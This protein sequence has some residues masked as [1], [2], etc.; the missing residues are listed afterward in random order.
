VSEAEQT[1]RDFLS[2]SQFARA[3]AVITDLDGTALHQSNGRTIIA[4][5]VELALKRLYELGRPFVLNSLRHP[6]SILRSF[7]QDW[8]RISNAPIP[9]VTLNGSLIGYIAL[10][11]SQNGSTESI[12]FEERAAFP[13]SHAQIDAAL[14]EAARAIAAGDPGPRL[15]CYPRRWPAGEI[16]WTPGVS[17]LSA[18]RAQL[19]SEDICMIHLQQTG[20]DHFVTRPGTDKLSGARHLT[21]L[22]PFDLAS[23]IG[24]GDTDMDSFLNGVGLALLVGDLPLQFRGRFRTLR[25]KDSLELGDLL[26]QL[27]GMLG[28]NLK[29]LT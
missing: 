2:H 20:R 11:S 23:S 12:V 29:A 24:A 7:G 10:N 9:T 21:E 15:F 28:R 8:Y 26:F 6:L 5:P 22:L 1:L 27:A 14:D 16:L 25:L 4:R 18:L 17:G 19:H 13:L 3:G